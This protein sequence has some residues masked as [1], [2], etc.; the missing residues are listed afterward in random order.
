[1]ADLK[2]DQYEL[3]KAFSEN[4]RVFGTLLMSN[5]PKWLGQIGKTGADFVFI[6]SEHA[7]LDRSDRAFICEGLKAQNIAPVVRIPFCNAYEAF[8]AIEDGAVGVVS[9]YL[10]TAEEVKTLIGAVKLRPLKGERLR[11]VLDGEEELSQKEKDYLAAYNKGNLLILNIESKAAVDR[12]DEL[13]SFPEVDA[14]FIG[15]HDLSINMGIPEEYDNP[16]FEEYIE[17]IIDACIRH[18]KGIGNH[19]S[20]DIQKQI[21]WAKKGMGVVLWSSDISEFVKSISSGLNA[22]KSALGEGDLTDSVGVTI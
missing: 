20:G 9:P 16:K 18:K 19:Y 7:P 14:V 13:L 1:G 15:P 10:E 8:A 4:S 12:L 6:D 3:K 5:S 21:Q 11:R 2:L 17:K 22:V